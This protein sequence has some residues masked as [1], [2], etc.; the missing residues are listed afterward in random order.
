MNSESPDSRCI[1]CRKPQAK[2]HCGS[3]REPVCQ[4]CRDHLDI[5]T[6]AFSENLPE[7]LTH[8]DYCSGCY[9]TIVEPAIERYQDTFER[10]KDIFIFFTTQKTRLPILKRDKNRLEIKVCRDRDELISRLAFKATEMGFNSV[11]EVEVKADKIRNAG[12]QKSS[13]HG[14]GYAA[15]VDPVKLERIDQPQYK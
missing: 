9:A 4:S 2:L 1:T 12:H 10:S 15:E 13:W 8:S 7:E 14:G 11:I 5:E 6:F 3:C